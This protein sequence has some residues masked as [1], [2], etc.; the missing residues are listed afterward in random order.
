MSGSPSS[1]KYSL[2]LPLI[3][4]TPICPHTL[5]NRPLVVSD[6]VSV[7]IQVDSDKPTYATFDGSNSMKISKDFEISVNQSDVIFNLLRMPNNEYF[8]V[9]KDKL[10]WSSSYESKN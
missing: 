5:S 10:M 7:K 3:I 6:S 9:L 1:R 2:Y 4:I 8:S